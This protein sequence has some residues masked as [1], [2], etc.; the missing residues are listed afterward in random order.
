MNTLNHKLN[1]SNS[2]F[3]LGF[4]R[5]MRIYPNIPETPKVE[6]V[7]ETAKTNNDEEEKVSS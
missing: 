7:V 6:E 4:D 3:K 5:R 2:N 1:V